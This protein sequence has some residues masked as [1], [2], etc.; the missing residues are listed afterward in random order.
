M[1]RPI[2]DVGLFAGIVGAAAI[3]FHADSARLG[4][5]YA[6][7]AAAMAFCMA[8]FW[9]TEAIPLAW[10]AAIPIAVMPVF[11]GMKPHHVGVE[12]VR[13]EVFLFLGGMMIAAAIEGWNLHKRIALT[14]MA[15][16]GRTPARLILGVLLATAFVSMWISNTASAVM[17]YPIAMGVVL[18]M[19]LKHG[20]ARMAALSTALML[21]V[22]YGANIGGWG[23]K[24]GTGPNVIISGFIEKKLGMSLSFLDW[25]MIGLP[26]MLAILPIAWARLAWYARQ[27]E[28]LH[29]DR[30]AMRA[31]LR[32]LGPMSAG[33]KATIAYFLLAIVF[34]VGFKPTM[35]TW[36]NDLYQRW[37]STLMSDGA[38]AMAAA[39]LMMATPVRGRGPVLR[40]TWLSRLDYGVIVLLGGGFALAAAVTSSGLHTWMGSMLSG[41]R[42]WSLPAVIF[43]TSFLMTG[44][45]E[46]MSNTAAITMM[47]TVLFTAMGT[48]E[49]TFRVLATAGIAAS[50]GF[51][52][53]AGTPPNTIV[54]ASGRVTAGQMAWVGLALDVL[55][56]AVIATILWL[57][58][59]I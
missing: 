3:A 43:A 42:G 34:W 32:A 16:I 52:L 22:A 35:E 38:I 47:Q 56:A 28:P 31:E 40:A 58:P 51:M 17:M 2:Q 36:H 48:G 33:E 30:D 25:F 26:V 44:M 8:A 21:A 1:R 19:E 7:V 29:V 13:A 15:A 57:N 27:R 14:I 46:F 59:W 24:I 39:L 11:G 55:G 10:T 23:S 54:M 4:G 45:T 37:K 12:Y 53:P 49:A 9:M 20:R 41:A 5:P 18:Q 50:C 6:G